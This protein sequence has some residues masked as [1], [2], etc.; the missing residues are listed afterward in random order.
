ME[1]EEG[2]LILQVQQLRGFVTHGS[3]ANIILRHALSVYKKS[4]TRFCFLVLQVSA[5]TV[6]VNDGSNYNK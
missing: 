3:H 2:I 5:C 6:L 4:V 1:P